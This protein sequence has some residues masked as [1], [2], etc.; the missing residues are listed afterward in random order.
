MNGMDFFDGEEK[1]NLV[2]YEGKL[3]V[4]NYDPMEFEIKA[5]DEFEYLHYHGNGK[6]VDL[7][8]GCINTSYIFS[9]CILSEGFSFGDHFDTSN[10]TIMDKMFRNCI[11]PAGFSLGEHF[12]TSKVTDMEWMF[13]NCRL[14]KGFPLG[15]HFDISKVRRKRSM[16]RGCT[17]YGVDVHEF[18]CTPNST[19]IISRLKK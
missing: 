11:V 7:P 6:S 12:D 1:S 4:F 2:H 9:D 10:V 3:G 5:S 14:P 17:Y 8:D 16:F 13:E 18:F 19:E 15:E